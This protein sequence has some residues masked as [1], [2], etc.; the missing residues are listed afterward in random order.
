LAE[1]SFNFLVVFLAAFSV[2]LGCS[3]P[4]ELRTGGLILSS[5]R[6][7]NGLIG[8]C[9]PIVTESTIFYNNRFTDQNYHSIDPKRTED[10]FFRDLK[11][12]IR[13]KKLSWIQLSD[14]IS[15]AIHSILSSTHSPLDSIPTSIR[16]DLTQAKVD[17]ACIF[18]DV[19]L[20]HIQLVGTNASD[21]TQI[22]S[23]GS[24]IRRKISFKCAIVN[25]EK[26]KTVY[27]KEI[28]QEDSGIQLDFLE[29]A[30]RLL[31]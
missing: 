2:F 15:K 16:N 28:V 26:N 6:L 30:I 21:S 12:V 14:D 7:S 24:S 11:F 3:S 13:S 1:K 8:F 23:L 17:F 10:A 9:A 19:R 22:N 5:I 31:F 18:Y 27:Y 25:I 20:M 4:Q 29:K